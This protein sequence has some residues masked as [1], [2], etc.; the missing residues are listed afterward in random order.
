MDRVLR[1]IFGSKGDEVTGNWRKLHN[2]ELRN[3]YSSTNFIR[4]I[5]SRR[6]RW[7]GHV[8]CMGEMINAHT[9]LVGNLEGKIPLRGHRRKWEDNIKMNLRYIRLES[10]DWIHLAQDRDRYSYG[11][12]N[13][14]TS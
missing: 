2:E 7:A 9:I 8:V 14:L 3:L 5:K 11:H 10:V 4:M 12:G 1:R 13:F 6:I